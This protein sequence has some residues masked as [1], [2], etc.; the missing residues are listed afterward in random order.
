[1]VKFQQHLQNEQERMKSAL[2]EKLEARRRKR[3]ESAID[4]TETTVPNAVDTSR[5]ARMDGVQT[6]KSESTLL[7]DSPTHTGNMEPTVE[8]S[9]ASPAVTIGLPENMSENDWLSLLISSPVFERVNEIEELLNQGIIA[10]G[11]GV[12][13][14]NRGRPYI[15]LKDAQWLCSG[16]LIPVDI[17]ELSPANFV[18]YRF[19][20]FVTQLLENRMNVPSVTLLLASNLPPNNYDNNAFRNSFFYEHSRQILFVREERLYSVGDFVVVIMHCLAHILVEDL[21][22]DQNPLFL[23]AFYKVRAFYFVVCCWIDCQKRKTCQC[24]L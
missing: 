13:G 8:N 12:L 24:F 7:S 10:G 17:N 19:G 4:K 21:S 20:V 6:A 23:R 15:D 3:R 18:V 2:K 14:A 5:A 1:M 22:D 11:N 16:D 9:S